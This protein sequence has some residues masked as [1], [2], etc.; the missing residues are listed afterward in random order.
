[1]ELVAEVRV[2]GMASASG[3]F[4]RERPWR[5][6]KSGK[7]RVWGPSPLPAPIWGAVVLTPPQEMGHQLVH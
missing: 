3:F 4:R 2:G 7:C 6:Q 5:I 1:M